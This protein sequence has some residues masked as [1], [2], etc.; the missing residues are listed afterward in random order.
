MLFKKS[1]FVVLSIAL[2][3][4]SL[5]FVSTALAIQSPQIPLAGKAIPQ[6][7]Q[8]MPT[9]TAQPGGT[10][11]TILGNQPVTLRMCEFKANVLP[12]GAVPGYAGTWVW[13]IPG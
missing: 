3:A 2:F 10:M 11:A 6:F 8:S 1:S 7:M 5:V 4:G 9:L 12:P 13:G